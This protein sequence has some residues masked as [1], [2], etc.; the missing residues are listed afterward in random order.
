MEKKIKSL[1]TLTPLKE[2]NNMS[3][4]NEYSDD[5]IHDISEACYTITNEN[6]QLTSNEKIQLR[7]RLLPIHKEV[8]Q[9]A[10][11][12]LLV[13]I[14]REIFKK[15]QDGSGLFTALASVVVDIYVSFK[16]NKNIFYA[17]STQSKIFSHNSRSKF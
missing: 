5:K 17:S 13:K 3:F 16:I 2:G 11:P 12:K 8:R 1:S 7:I 6:I 10:N 15:R 4:I 9:L 14:K